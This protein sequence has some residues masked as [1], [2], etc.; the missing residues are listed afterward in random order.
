MTDEE[1][2]VTDLPVAEEPKAGVID[3][4]MK[5]NI[6]PPGEDEELVTVKVTVDVVQGHENLT[7]QALRDAGS[8]EVINQLTSQADPEVAEE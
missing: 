4:K 6:A 1:Y 3:I 7:L 8:E 2:E 5:Y